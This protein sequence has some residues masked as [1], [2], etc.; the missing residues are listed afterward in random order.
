MNV[1]LFRFRGIR[2]VHV[3][4]SCYKLFSFLLQERNNGLHLRPWLSA[5]M[6]NGTIHQSPI[7]IMENMIAGMLGSSD[8]DVLM[9]PQ[10]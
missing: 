3:V 1:K 9:R 4:G 7:L 6:L 8:G 2:T 5:T 10:P